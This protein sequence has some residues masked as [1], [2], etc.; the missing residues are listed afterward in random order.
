VVP[1]SGDVKVAVKDSSG[2][3]VANLDL[4][5]QSAGTIPFNWNG[6]DSNGNS[7]A[8]GNYTLSATVSTGSGTTAAT[9]QVAAQVDSVTLGS[10]G[11]LL[12]LNGIGQVALS[13]VTQII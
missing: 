13:Q 3:V 5:T 12:N 8:S 9:T 4:G 7:L 6:K 1:S 11:L 10:S 2:V